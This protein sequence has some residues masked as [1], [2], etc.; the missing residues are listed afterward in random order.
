MAWGL[1]VEVAREG[2]AAETECKVG[3]AAVTVRKVEA[4]L[5]AEVAVVEGVGRG[6]RRP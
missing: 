1:W 4:P 3:V 2:V 5:E 6:A